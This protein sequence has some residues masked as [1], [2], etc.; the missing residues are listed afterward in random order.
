MDHP[1]CPPPFCHRPDPT[2]VLYWPRLQSH[3]RLH[4]SATHPIH[5]R[6]FLPL[7]HITQLTLHNRRPRLSQY[8]RSARKNPSL[9]RRKTQPARPSAALCFHRPE[10]LWPLRRIAIIYSTRDWSDAGG[11]WNATRVFRR[12]TKV[13][14]VDRGCALC[15][16]HDQY[17]RKHSSLQRLSLGKEEYMQ[18]DRFVL[19]LALQNQ[20]LDTDP[21]NSKSR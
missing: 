7:L 20:K 4:M 1:A 11:R 13:G 18:K 16:R 3:Y 21:R 17:N 12:G 14:S 5:S 10:D 9:D 15:R 8:S 2:S 19:D 6:S